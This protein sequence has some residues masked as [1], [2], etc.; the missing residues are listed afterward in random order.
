[1]DN[2][3]SGWRDNPANFLDACEK[4]YNAFSD[5]AKQS[6]LSVNPVDFANIKNK[7]ETIIRLE[8]NKEKRIEAWKEAVNEGSLFEKSDQEALNYSPYYWKQQKDD[9][10]DLDNSHE[11]ISK[12]VYRFHQAAIYHRNYTLKQL[13]PKH[14]I[15]VL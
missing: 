9:F 15:L 13:L 7:V 4:L 14:G 5:Y 3:D 1:M 10:E 12:D 2:K 11:M 6:G 8:A